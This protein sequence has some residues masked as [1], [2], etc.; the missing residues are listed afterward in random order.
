M[1]TIAETM[2]YLMQEQDLQYVW[3]GDLHLLE[4]CAQH[5]HL[6]KKHPA[7]MLQSVLNGLDRSDLFQKGY[8]YADCNGKKRKFRCF[9]PVCRK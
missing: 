7:N 6:K 3:M 2:Y 5:C 8:L 9:S 1:Q 4:E